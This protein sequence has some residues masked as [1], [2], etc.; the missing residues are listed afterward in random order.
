MADANNNKIIFS[1]VKSNLDNR[2]LEKDANGYRKIALGAFNVFNSSG[3]FYTMNGIKELFT[4]SSSSLI[5]RIKRGMLKSEAGHPKFMPGMTKDEYF[6]RIMRIEETNVCAHIRDLELE[7]TS[8]DS[9]MKGK[10]L[11]IVY[12]WVAPSGPHADAMERAFDNPDENVAFSIRS[13]TR[14]YPVG[15]IMFKDI[16]QIH[17]WDWVTEP[18]IF[19][20]SKWRTLGI[21]SRQLSTGIE[22]FEGFVFNMDE[23]ASEK[24][25][26]NVCLNCSLESDDARECTKELIDNF[27]KKPKSLID[28]W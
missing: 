5:R 2:V 24:K 26:I 15:G 17:T 1:S 6:S 11:V 28:R 21:E 9:G 8:D 23:I 13:F 25:D 3:Q 7:Y 19:G 20:A 27:Y 12:G 18:G 14:D 4:E 16:L 22:S 10:P